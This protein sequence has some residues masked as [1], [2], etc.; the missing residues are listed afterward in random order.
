MKSSVPNSERPERRSSSNP[1]TRRALLLTV[2][3]TLS[4]VGVQ[5]VSAEPIDGKGN[6]VCPCFFDIDEVEL[7]SDDILSVSG[8]CAVLHPP[9]AATVSVRVHG[10]GGARATGSETIV[11]TGTTDDESRFTLSASIRGGTRFETGD[12]ITVHARVHIRPD[13]TPAVTGRWSWSGQLS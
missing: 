7:V 11:C 1:L 8:P 6:D 10:S 12:E 2:P 9:E 5:S 4:I 3:A 13:R